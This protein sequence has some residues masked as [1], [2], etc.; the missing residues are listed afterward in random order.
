[1]VVGD[2]LQEEMYFS[3]LSALRASFLFPRNCASNSNSDNH[4]ACNSCNVDEKRRLTRERCDNYC[5]SKDKEHEACRLPEKI[6]CGPNMPS[7]TVS[8][9][10]TDSLSLFSSGYNAHIG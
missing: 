5:V 10:R 6:D 3:F 8:F 9:A 1:M 2:S 7:F 4:T